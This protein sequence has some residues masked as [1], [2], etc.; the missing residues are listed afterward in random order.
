M[1]ALFLQSAEDV[2]REIVRLQH[3]YEFLSYGMIIAWLILVV[4]LLTMV[5]R[6]KSLK[7]EIA[8]LRAMLEEKPR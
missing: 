8:G 6:E 7:R 3:G 1:Y 4:Y 2:T 5:S